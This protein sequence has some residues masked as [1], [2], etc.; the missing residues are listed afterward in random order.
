MK[1]NI[2]FKLCLAQAKPHLYAWRKMGMLLKENEKY[3]WLRLKK[4]KEFG[5]VSFNSSS[6][7][8]SIHAIKVRELK[9]VNKLKFLHLY[10]RGSPTHKHEKQG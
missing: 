1:E 4:K 2:A 5:V 3:E 10:P 8:Y 7:L 9:W 6:Y